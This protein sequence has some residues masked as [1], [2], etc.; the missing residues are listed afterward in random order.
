MR[1]ITRE[2]PREAWLD[3]ATALLRIHEQ[4]GIRLSL[5]QLLE[6]CVAE[7]CVAHLDC[8]F[9]AGP[10]PADQLFVRRIKGA[11]RCELLV[12]DALYVA[13]PAAGMPPQLCA[14]GT[15]LVRGRAWV[16]AGDRQ[17]PCREDG[18]W[19]LDLVRQRRPLCF[20]A[21]EVAR[22]AVALRDGELPHDVLRRAG[23]DWRLR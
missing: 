20:A 8:S 9:A 4:G 16:Y 11:G 3:S 7:R 14:G 12:A 5:H 13:T 23:G 6:L 2:S 10:A 17:R 1:T 22:L 18:I 15:L 21:S 19:H